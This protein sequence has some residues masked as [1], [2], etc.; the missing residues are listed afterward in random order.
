M[1]I[2]AISNI[3]KNVLS[4]AET[5][6]SKPTR[7]L[8]AHLRKASRVAVHPLRHKMAADTRQSAAT[9]GNHR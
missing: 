2:G 4:R 3:L 7:A 5:T 6:F 1:E 9:F 8:S